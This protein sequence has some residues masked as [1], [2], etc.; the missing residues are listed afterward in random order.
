MSISRNT[1]W[2]GC[3][4]KTDRGPEPYFEMR[5]ADKSSPSRSRIEY[6]IAVATMAAMLVLPSPCSLLFA[7]EFTLQYD[8]A[9][10]EQIRIISQSITE[11]YP[12]GEYFLTGISGPNG[13]WKVVRIESS[14]YCDNDLCP[15]V[16]LSS[17]LD[18][19]VAIKAG[20]ELAVLIELG[21]W[22]YIQMKFGVDG[23][24]NIVLRYF[25]DEKV[26]SIAR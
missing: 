9:S 4:P 11:A 21:K 7:M 24:S 23:A 3:V 26:L 16:V 1:R 12:D 19:K 2:E 17:E 8:P 20:R 25:P 13:E 10:K 6:V 15:I 14:K 22:G 18:W 5:S